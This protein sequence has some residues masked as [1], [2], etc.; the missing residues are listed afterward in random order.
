V[1]PGRKL[2]PAKT[3]VF[4]DMLQTALGGIAL[5]GGAG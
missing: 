3:R 1:F 2:M 4:I 5:E